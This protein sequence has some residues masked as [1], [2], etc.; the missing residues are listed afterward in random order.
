MPLAIATHPN[1]VVRPWI[2]GLLPDIDQVIARWARRFHVSPAAFAL[3]GTQVGIDRAGAVQFVPVDSVDETDI[4]Q[5]SVEWLSEEQ[6]TQRL[7]DLKLDAASWLGVDFDGRFSLAGAQAKPAL[8]SKD[9]RWGVP[10]GAT[11]TTHILK[12]AINGLDDH[13]LNEHICFRAAARMGLPTAHSFI[14]SFAGERTVVVER[15]DRVAVDGMVRRIHQEDLCQALS[16]DPS[17]KYESDGG[18]GVRGVAVLLRDVMPTELARSALGDFADSL[19]FNWA[20]GGTDAHA[21]NYSLLLREE[22]VVLAPLY[23]LASALPYEHSEHKLKLAMKIGSDYGLNMQRPQL[24]ARLASNLRLPEDELVDRAG[25][26]LESLPDAFSTVCSDGELAGVDSALPAQLTEAVAKRAKVCL[27]SLP[28]RGADTPWA[29]A[30]ANPRYSPG[31]V[32]RIYPQ[33]R[34]DR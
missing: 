15:Y 3:L 22:R 29:E 1:R 28:V 19:I 27:R 8:L 7:R 32:D 16:I 14:R 11:A 18:P 5:G 4:Q 9:G 33:M 21:K 25:D 20:I 26:L 13:D 24:W 10:S 34:E 6:V 23:D 17:R 12:P 2:A 30:D 31:G